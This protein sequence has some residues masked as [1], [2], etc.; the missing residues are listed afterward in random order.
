MLDFLIDFR[1][2]YF[3]L[4]GNTTFPNHALIWPQPQNEGSL[5]QLGRGHPVPIL[6]PCSACW[7]QACFLCGERRKRACYSDYLA[8]IGSLFWRFTHQVVHDGLH[9]PFAARRGWPALAACL[10]RFSC[11][12]SARVIVWWASSA[13]GTHRKHSSAGVGFCW[14]TELSRL[15][16]GWGQG[17]GHCKAPLGTAVLEEMVAG[18]KDGSIWLSSF[19]P[20]LGSHSFVE[21]CL[22]VQVCLDPA[23]CQPAG[24]A[25]RLGCNWRGHGTSKVW[26]CPAKKHAGCE[27]RLLE[28]PFGA[29][30][31]FA[32]N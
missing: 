30:L 14:V 7:R 27:E 29:D 3:S 5:L 1:M 26:W 11:W 28:T 16:L 4:W 20:S 32:E 8:W 22:Q 12:F 23:H 15:P 2:L 24:R 18:G 9:R 6:M 19:W 13:E 21:Q 25:K 10:C 17:S 31:L